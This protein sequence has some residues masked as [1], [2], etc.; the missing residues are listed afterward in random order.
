MLE[1]VFAAGHQY[2]DRIF[3]DK[4]EGKYYDRHTDYY[5][6]DDQLAAYGL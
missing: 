6:A 5:L 3:W 1:K 4:T 2:H